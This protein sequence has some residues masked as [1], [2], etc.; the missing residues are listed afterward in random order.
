M[1]TCIYDY[2]SKNKCIKC[3][4]LIHEI[5]CYQGER[6]R[7]KEREDE[8]GEEGNERDGKEK[9][10][11]K[12]DARERKMSSPCGS[13][14]TEVISVARRCEEREGEKQR[15]RKKREKESV[16]REN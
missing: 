3:M 5:A 12:R 10:L 13:L 14:V 8:E 15:R 11:G 7:E 1:I 6:R 16:E 4:I 2:I 9:R